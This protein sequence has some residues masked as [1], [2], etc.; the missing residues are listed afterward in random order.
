MRRRG[1]GGAG[2]AIDRATL[3]MLT[4]GDESL[5]RELLT[6]Y[7]ERTDFLIAALRAGAPVGEIAHGAKGSALAVGDA[8]MAA[9]AAGL[10][11]LEGTVGVAGREALAAALETSGDGARRAL[12]M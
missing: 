3:H 12:K 2:L 10:E 11:G 6:I 5:A 7:V 8:A 1:R 9:V 4:L